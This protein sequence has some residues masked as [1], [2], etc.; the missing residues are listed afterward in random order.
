ME[1]EGSKEVWSEAMDAV[2]DCPARNLD[3]SRRRYLRG[4][5][6]RMEGHEKG[7]LDFVYVVVGDLDA[8]VVGCSILVEILR[9]LFLQEVGLAAFHTK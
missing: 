1:S 5:G 6:F 8:Y 9:R 4:I 2:G 3:H 7:I